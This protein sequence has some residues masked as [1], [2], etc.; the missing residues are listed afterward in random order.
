MSKEFCEKVRISAMT[1]LDGEEP[2]LS[3]NEVNEHIEHCADCRHELEQ[4][5][6]V[7][8][9]LHGQNRRT[10]AENVWPTIA[11]RI[12]R[13]AKPN[14]LSELLLFVLLGIFLLA[15]KIIEVLPGITP[16]VTIKLVPLA[17]V[18]VFFRVLKQNPL[19]IRP[20]LRLEGNTK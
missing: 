20:N 11:A 19:E 16:S 17:I 1:I 4:Q 5:K 6:Q 2:I 12:E 9:I 3:V 10:F 14:R 15:Y 18:F 13:S 7:D 8:A